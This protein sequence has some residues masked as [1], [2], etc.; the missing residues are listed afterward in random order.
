M[1]TSCPIEV[2]EGC[3]WNSR[4][5]QT[6]DKYKPVFRIVL[7][8][9]LLTIIRAQTTHDFTKI[10]GCSFKNLMMVVSSSDGVRSL[11]TFFRWVTS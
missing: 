8:L 5:N 4:R 1:S 3:Y 9:F 2:Q 6:L 10:S 11:K 7:S